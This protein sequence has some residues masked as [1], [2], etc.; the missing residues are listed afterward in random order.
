MNIMKNMFC[1]SKKGKRYLAIYL[2][3]VVLN[4]VL[5]CFGNIDEFGTSF[6]PFNGDKINHSWGYGRGYDWFEFFVYTVGPI[7]IGIIIKL[8]KD[9]RNDD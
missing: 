1:L 7:V 8:F 2:S 3:W 4:F 5:L 9:S 6:W